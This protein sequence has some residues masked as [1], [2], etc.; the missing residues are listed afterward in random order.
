M[1]VLALQEASLS[2]KRWRRNPQQR[3]LAEKLK[4]AIF[5]C[6]VAGQA[7]FSPPSI[8]LVRQARSPIASVLIALKQSAHLGELNRMFY[9][10]LGRLT[11]NK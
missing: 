7:F 9:R 2:P 8:F 11:I 1:E 4:R 10:A 6:T 5:D 3:E